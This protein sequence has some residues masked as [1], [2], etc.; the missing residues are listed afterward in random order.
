MTICA[1]AVTVHT[2]KCM[3]FII[4]VISSHSCVPQLESVFISVKS[5]CRIQRQT[6]V[7][8]LLFSG[9]CGEEIVQLSFWGP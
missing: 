4:Y 2:D 5:K 6:F 3:Y 7:Y 9:E 8:S 1:C